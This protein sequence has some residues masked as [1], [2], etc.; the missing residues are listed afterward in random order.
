MGKVISMQDFKKE[1][2]AMANVEETNDAQD[3]TLK[4]MLESTL[5]DI[6][7]GR[8]SPDAKGIICIND[9]DLLWNNSQCDDEEAQYLLAEVLV[10]YLPR[11]SEEE[12]N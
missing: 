5:K 6:E 10:N 1:R 9:G 4:E 12:L 11:V 3:W 7:E 8:I 2:E